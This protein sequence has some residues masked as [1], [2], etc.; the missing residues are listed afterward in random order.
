MPSKPA[1][2]VSPSTRGFRLY[3]DL[4]DSKLGPNSLPWVCLNGSAATFT[5]LV[6][7]CVILLFSM[8]GLMVL[9]YSLGLTQTAYFHWEILYVVGKKKIKTPIIKA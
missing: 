8:P 2:L 4:E 1:E 5:V 7:L 6:S 9:D 3:V